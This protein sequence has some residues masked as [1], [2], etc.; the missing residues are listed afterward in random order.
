MIMG[1]LKGGRENGPATRAR[2]TRSM[3][4][5][6]NEAVLRARSEGKGVMAVRGSGVLVGRVRVGVSMRR[7]VHMRVRS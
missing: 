4:V 6:V 1:W 7:S 3:Q 5:S 2:S